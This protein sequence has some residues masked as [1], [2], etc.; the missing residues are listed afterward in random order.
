MEFEQILSEL[1]QFN[2]FFKGEVEIPIEKYT[3]TMPSLQQTDPTEKNQPENK[4]QTISTTIPGNTKTDDTS[5]QKQKEK[6]IISS[7]CKC[8][9]VILKPEGSAKGSRCLLLYAPPY[10]AILDESKPELEVLPANSEFSIEDRYLYIVTSFS[11]RKYSIKSKL[12]VFQNI[13]R[14]EFKY[15]TVP[16]ILSKLGCDK[17]LTVES[18]CETFIYST[19]YS[20]SFFLSFYFMDPKLYSKPELIENWVKACM[21]MI[22]TVMGRLFDIF[23]ND[24]DITSIKNPLELFPFLVVNQ[25]LSMDEQFK[26]YVKI[27]AEAN[28]PDLCSFYLR[29]LESQPFNQR[30][31]MIL[32]LLHFETSIKYPDSQYPLK[33]VSMAMYDSALLPMALNINPNFRQAEL[34]NLI[35]FQQTA[36]ALDNLT[37]YEKILG[38]FRKQPRDY[39]PPRRGATAAD[40]LDEI[41]KYVGSFPSEYLRVARIMEKINL[42]P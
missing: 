23:I 15:S 20:E 21:P 7:K 31:L 27:I 9:Y 13:I 19:I 11:E 10:C 18:M 42:S 14:S 40:G 33:M 32:H 28:V 38:L 37:K 26:D 4:V 36:I 35:E 8:F 12:D 41:L 24:V 25:I 29:C 5:K 2:A 39:E 6:T 30:S 17:D 16:Y 34:K 22:D 1:A 3:M